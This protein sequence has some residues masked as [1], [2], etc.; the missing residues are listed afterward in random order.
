MNLYTD[1]ERV[2]IQEI[3]RLRAVLRESEEER[4]ALEVRLNSAIGEI[5]YLKRLLNGR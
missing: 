5:E 2:M 1:D 3:R 4:G